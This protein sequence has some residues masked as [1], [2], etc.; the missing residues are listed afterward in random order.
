MNSSEKNK[1]EF[2]DCALQIVQAVFESKLWLAALHYLF[3]AWGLQGNKS[4]EKSGYKRLMNPLHLPFDVCFFSLK[5]MCSQL[6]DSWSIGM[7]HRSVKLHFLIGVCFCCSNPDKKNT[8]PLFLS[9]GKIYWMKTLLAGCFSG[10]P[11]ELWQRHAQKERDRPAHLRSAHPDPPLV[12]VRQ[13]HSACRGARMHR[14]GVRPC[15]P[16]FLPSFPAPQHT[17]VSRPVF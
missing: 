4:L 9:C 8:S 17:G 16:S 12:M 10:V 15:P 14:G 6:A 11:G 2:R 3:P 7:I 1:A 5:D 13:D